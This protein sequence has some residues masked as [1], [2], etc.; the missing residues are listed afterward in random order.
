MACSNSSSAF[1]PVC[2]VYTPE[3]NPEAR[4]LLGHH[5]HSQP[6]HNSTHTYNEKQG[7]PIPVQDGSHRA[8]KA[9]KKKRKILKKLAGLVLLGYIFFHYI[10]PALS[11]NHS[12]RHQGH[13]DIAF[14]SNDLD[15]T[16]SPTLS[17][18]TIYH[19]DFCK[20]YAVQ[21][22]GPSIFS[23]TADRFRLNFGKG[24]LVSKVN[25]L[26]AQVNEPTLKLTAYVSPDDNEGQDFTV[27]ISQPA[28]KLNIKSVIKIDHLGLNLEII[29]DEDLF[30]VQ[31]WYENH[32]AHTPEGHEYH[33][34]ARVEVQVLFPESYTSYKELTI[35][36]PV[37]D[38]R[39][40]NLDNIRF[41]LL[42]FGVA[43][44]NVVATNNLLADDFL[45]EVKTGRVEIESVEAATKDAPLKVAANV[46]TGHATVHAKTKPAQKAH[47]VIVA[48][49][50]GSVQVTVSTSSSSS[51]S[52]VNKP[53]DLNIQAKSKVGSV[54]ANVQL[55]S[56]QQLLRLDA[57]SNTGS[58]SAQISD[59]FSGRLHVETRLGSTYVKEASGS[60]SKIE[61]QKQTGQV[62]DGVKRFRDEE[63]QEGEV[64]LKSTLG[65]VVL[66]FA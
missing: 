65:R 52:S 50:T 24:N 54:R 58:V 17:G 41:D 21:W 31:I 55:E 47:E 10:L 7:L 59:E 30:D 4:P 61:Y 53:A 13:H 26:T 39:A 14:D 66:E 64:D 18:D 45:A 57:S 15:N 32:S 37:V 44:G 5:S 12:H 38:I 51:S 49:N 25:I 28:D 8:C 2:C 19:D 40:N 34:C 43:V 23:T 60:E 9:A 3:G 62:K 27:P 35:S 33:A 36:G 1:E 20:T 56:R 11:N 42:A 46:V 63:V 16:S 29:D 48:S 22:D 6:V